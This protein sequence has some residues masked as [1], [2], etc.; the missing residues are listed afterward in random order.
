MRDKTRYASRHAAIEERLVAWGRW[1]V[2]R[3]EGASGYPKKSS[4]ARLS[5]S[6][7]DEWQTRVDI[8]LR[9]Y[10]P[11]GDVEC[12]QTDDSIKTLPPDLVKLVRI[13]YMRDYGMAVAADQ[14]GIS[15]STLYKR[16]LQVYQRLTEY[17]DAFREKQQRRRAA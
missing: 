3:V 10:V 17:F 14:L 2:Q 7:G 11:I 16:R 8:A 13:V 4:F 15:T 12:S 9:S 5:A 1:A 6:G